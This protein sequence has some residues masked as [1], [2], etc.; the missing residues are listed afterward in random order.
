MNLLLDDL[1]AV[2][3]G[4]AGQAD[5]L[6]IRGGVLEILLSIFVPRRYSPRSLTYT[7]KGQ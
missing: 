2:I 7:R 1:E 3:L 6:C 4:I 5:G